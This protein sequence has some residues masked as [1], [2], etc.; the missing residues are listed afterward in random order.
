MSGGVIDTVNSPRQPFGLP[1]GSVRGFLSL[2]ICGFVWMVLLLPGEGKLPLSHFF[3]MVL[4]LMAFSSSPRTVS[5]GESHFLPWLLRVLF[6][7][8]SVGV[9]A[10]SLL[11]DPHALVKLT[12][13][14]DEFAQWWGPY[15][16]VL[17]GGFALG[18]F[19]RFVLGR[20][21]HVFQT[22]R[23][24]LATVG[25]VMMGLEFLLYLVFNSAE[26]KQEQFMHVWQAVELAVVSAYF[27][28]RT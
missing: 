2:L 3:L 23:A 18:L 14:A 5:V 6:V 4:V 17:A 21:N 20:D 11:R 9:V 27:G 10:Y 19:L 16:A 13:P 28:T 22:V 1:Q 8:G 24:W 12:P 15:L 25:L 26:N 7:G